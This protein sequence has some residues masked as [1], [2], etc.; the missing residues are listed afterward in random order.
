[1]GSGPP[2]HHHSS[3]AWMSRT[4]VTSRMM[5]RATN[6]SRTTLHSWGKIWQLTADPNK[7]TIHTL[8]QPSLITLTWGQMIRTT[9]KGKATDGRKERRQECKGSGSPPINK[10]KGKNPNQMARTSPSIKF[11]IT[12]RYTTAASGKGHRHLNEGVRIEHAGRH[13]GGRKKG[14]RSSLFL[15]HAHET[16]R[17]S[18]FSFALDLKSEFKK[19]FI[20]RFWVSY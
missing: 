13:P 5:R 1:M 14:A 8:S 18:S 20:Q 2:L 7:R 15:C 4:N 16:C 12:H 17:V 6:P 19:D 3:M 11:W 10:V 9:G